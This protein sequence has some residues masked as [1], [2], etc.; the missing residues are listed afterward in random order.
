[1]LD[2]RCL[3]VQYGCSGIIIVAWW[4]FCG[5]GI[6]LFGFDV[7]F[8]LLS[9]LDDLLFVGFDLVVY[10]DLSLWLRVAVCFC[11]FWVG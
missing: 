7:D 6:W 9:L 10:F 4:L 11:E 3:L 1:M 5:F 2:I 8:L